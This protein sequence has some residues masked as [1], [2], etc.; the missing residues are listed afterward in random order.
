MPQIR[1]Q[2]GLAV[3]KEN[4]AQAQF[5]GVLFF[6]V[7]LLMQIA[8][9]YQFVTGNTTM[10]GRPADTS[11]VF[12]WLLVIFFPAVFWVV[13]LFIALSG[14]NSRYETDDF[15]IRKFD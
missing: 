14:K 15:G 2:N 5:V 11:N 10:N 13:G 1:R 9:P 3:I 6:S 4:G 8:L 12:Q 7:G